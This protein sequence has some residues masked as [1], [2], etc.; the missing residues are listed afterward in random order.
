MWSL[1]KYQIWIHTC[2]VTGGPLQIIIFKAEKYKYSVAANSEHLIMIYKI[3]KYKI[4]RL[5]Q[6]WFLIN[7][8]WKFRIHAENISTMKYF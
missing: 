6:A 2:V 5:K 8:H 1:R 7:K 3:N 4:Y